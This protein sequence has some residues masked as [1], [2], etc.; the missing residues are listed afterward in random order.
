ME[1]ENWNVIKKNLWKLSDEE[2]KKKIIEIEKDKTKLESR[3]FGKEG[4]ST[5][6][7]NYPSGKYEGRYGNLRNLKKRIAYMKTILN[8][9]K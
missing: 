9:R 4:S 7:R 1:E 6:I 2:L 8:T 5:L 3:M